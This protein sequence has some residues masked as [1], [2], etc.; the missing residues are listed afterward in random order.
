MDSD[1]PRVGGR[2]GKGCLADRMGIKVIPWN[3]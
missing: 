1:A 2:K 3:E